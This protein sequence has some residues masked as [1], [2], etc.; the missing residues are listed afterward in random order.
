[1]G[2]RP[3]AAG[4]L[5]RP[6]RPAWVLRAHQYRDDVR[7][8]QTADGAGCVVLGRGLAGRW[9]VA[10]EVEPHARGRGLGRALA[11][12]ALGLLP[13]GT[14]VFAQVSPGNS[15]SLRAVLAAGYAPIA[16]EVLLR[17]RSQPALASGRP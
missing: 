3:A 6:A 10:F 2:P 5:Q 9:E 14:P 13:A 4:R 12:A 1:M 11:S 15:I 17:P 7:V 8:W 16:A